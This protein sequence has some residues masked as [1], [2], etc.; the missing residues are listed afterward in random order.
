MIL[1]RLGYL[2]QNHLW[3]Q[4]VWSA[5]ECQ[6][7][8]LRPLGEAKVCYLKINRKIFSILFLKHVSNTLTKKRGLA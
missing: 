2:R 6:G 5:A 7:G 8:F 4:V 3:S 1:I